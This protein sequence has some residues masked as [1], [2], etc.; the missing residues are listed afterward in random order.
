MR[1]HLRSMILFSLFHVCAVLVLFFRKYWSSSSSEDTFLGF[2]VGSDGSV[3]DGPG[4][5]VEV[6][7][8][9][10]RGRGRGFGREDIVV[11][12]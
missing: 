5:G 8:G 10:A 4:V 2:A 12:G 11:I 9:S 3:V 6:E 1:I 7:A